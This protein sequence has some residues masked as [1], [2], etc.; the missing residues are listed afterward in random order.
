MAR[1]VG[2]KEMQIACINQE[3]WLGCSCIYTIVAYC[4][5]PIVYIPVI[6]G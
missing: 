4:Y 2:F 5:F 1:R 3:D 6:L